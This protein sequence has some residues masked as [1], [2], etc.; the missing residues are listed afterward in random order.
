M[1]RHS[2]FLVLFFTLLVTLISSEVLDCV[3]WAKQAATPHFSPLAEST[4]PASTIPMLHLLLRSKTLV[5]GDWSCNPSW[6]GDNECDCGCGIIDIDCAGPND[7]DCRYCDACNPI[8]D[9]VSVVD[10]TQ[11]WLCEG[12]SS[13]TQAICQS[14]K[15]FFWLK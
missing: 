10:D 12:G 8:I 7:S 14:S 6:Y 9:C 13:S 4:K 15:I 1:K 5:L 3:S 2:F 11:N